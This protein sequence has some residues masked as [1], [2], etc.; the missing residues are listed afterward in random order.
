MSRERK[1]VVKRHFIVQRGNNC[2]IIAHRDPWVHT[3]N[4]SCKDMVVIGLKSELCVW[5]GGTTF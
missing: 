3:L 4:P 5:R 1:Q 2:F